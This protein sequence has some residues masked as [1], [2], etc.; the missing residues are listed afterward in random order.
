[1]EQDMN[2]TNDV[3]EE[4]PRKKNKWMPAIGFSLLIL[5]AFFAI[6]MVGSIAMVLISVIIMVA[7][8]PSEAANIQSQMLGLSTDSNYISSITTVCIFV[9]AIAAMIWYYVRDVRKSDRGNVGKVIRKVTTVKGII[10]WISGSVF[11]FGC[12]VFLSELM[13]L[14]SPSAM[15]MFN[16]TMDLALGGNEIISFLTVVVLAPIAEE[17]IF[18]GL[19]LNTLKKRV[20]FIAVIVIQAI[21]FGIYHGNIIQAVYVLPAAIFLG[22]VAYK[23]GSVIPCMFIHALYNSMSY[24]ANALPEEATTTVWIAVYTVLAGVI[25]FVACKYIGRNGELND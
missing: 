7:K 13:G 21:C 17:L 16:D 5:F 1:M 20:P 22:I 9:S 11:C 12:A 8:N 15:D 10:I 2:I 14:L 4:K 3:M 19:I 6:Q 25:L 24:I 23:M 18:R